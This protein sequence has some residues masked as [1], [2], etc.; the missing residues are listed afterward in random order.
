[1]RFRASQPA[2]SA[3]LLEQFGEP[4]ATFGPNMRFRIRS[5][6]L[7]IFLVI[8][9]FTFVVGGP[10]ILQGKAMAGVC[11]YVPLGCGL[12][13]VGVMSIVVP[14]RLPL[15]WVFVCPRGLIRARGEI[16]EAVDWADIVHFQD[17]SM[18]GSAVTIQQC[19]I[20]T[21]QPPELAFRSNGVLR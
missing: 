18:S 19:L 8:L 11:V 12:M 14:I 1:M 10:A 20:V 16:W 13:L 21:L 15:N 17:A 9:G 2:I 7:G 6:L 3:D 4:E 5:T